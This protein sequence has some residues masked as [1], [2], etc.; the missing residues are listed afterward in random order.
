[1]RSRLSVAATLLLL[2]M[3]AGCGGG[4]KQ[5]GIASWYGA[6]FAGRQTA[7]GERF[8]PAALTA[9]HRTLPFGTLAEVTALDT[10]RAIVVRITDR[11]PFRRERVIDLSAGAARLLGV[12]RRPT[13]VRVRALP[14]GSRLRPG[15][16]REGRTDG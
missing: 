8:D 6:A 14:R 7:S 1:M 10:G 5:T 9:A 11:G 12:E 3:L 4:Y 15:L 13:R 2:A 16:L